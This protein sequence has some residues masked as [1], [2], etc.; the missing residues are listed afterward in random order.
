M[1]Q[2]ERFDTVIL[3]SG[4]GGKA[5]A[6]HLG[7]TG[8]RTAVV[9]RQW[10]G[11]SCP[12]VAC[13]PSKNEIY[14]ARVGYLARHAAAYGAVNG[15]IKTD[16]ASVRQRKRAMVDR[17]VAFHLDAY[18]KSGAKLI[19]GIGHFTAP[20]TIEVQLNDGGRRLLAG[21]Q[22]VLNVG[23]HAAIPEI[24]GLADARPLTHIEALELDHAPS[25]LVVLG[26][27]Y[28]G[29]EMAQAYRRFGSQVTVIEPS[30][31][32]LGR[33]DA[34]VAASV[35]EVLSEE[36]V[37][38]LCSTQVLGVQGQSGR[39]VTLTV[40]AADGERAIEASDILVAAGR[41]P[42]TAGIGLDKAGVE[43]DNRGYIRVN[44]R[45]QAT[46]PD[47]WA[48]GECA[49]SPQFTHVSVDDFRIVRDNMAGGQRSTHD[50]L[51]PHCLFT[52]PP[53]AHV[54]LTERE[55]ERQGI[56]ARVAKLPMNAVLRTEA[57]DEAQGFMKVLVAQDDDR[58]LGFTMLGSEAG[59]VMAAV[60][61]AMLAKA[62]YP[63]VRDAVIAHLTFAEGLGPLLSTIG[64]RKAA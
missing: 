58:I 6:W 39:K 30:P 18:K 59:E 32:I 51:V 12:S 1:A 31:Q 41:V 24:T 27:G 10:V 45:L 35:Q 55:A 13:L 63:M 49:G 21:D 56:A 3:G 20:K 46:A 48:I 4:Q 17:E 14:S 40:R 19:M 54:G 44:E 7:Q 26:G 38:F 43:L 50:R 62:P 16:M 2:P 37:V 57:T 61:M 60:Q 15:A 5:L 53:L 52:D 22:I 33:E 8:R 25:H 11:G 36:G 29:L 23:T 34:D 9:E 64:E 47:V 28:T 42:N